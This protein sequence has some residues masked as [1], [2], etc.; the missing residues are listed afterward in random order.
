LPELAIAENGFN[1]L[2]DYNPEP[3]LF[4]IPLT[5]SKLYSV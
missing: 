5:I 4:K 3:I 2:P 1:S